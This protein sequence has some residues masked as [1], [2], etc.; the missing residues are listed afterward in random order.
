MSVDVT[1]TD[2]SSTAVKASP[3]FWDHV[4]SAHPPLYLMPTL[5]RFICIYLTNGNRKLIKTCYLS[6]AHPEVNAKRLRALGKAAAPAIPTNA[7]QQVPSLYQP[8]GNLSSRQCSPWALHAHQTPVQ[9]QE[10]GNHFSP[11]FP[12]W[13]GK[14]VLKPS[15]G[16]K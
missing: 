11:S 13:G 5:N 3:V 12:V 16:C 9:D 6:N 2:T 14:K 15:K 7:K 4:C 1:V 10:H 8:P